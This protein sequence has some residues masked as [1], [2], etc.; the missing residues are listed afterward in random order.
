MN[1]RR[2]RLCLAIVVF[3]S[4][5]WHSLVHAQ[6]MTKFRLYSASDGISDD[7]ITAI[8]QD[9]HGYLW[10]STQ[11]GLNRYDGRH[12]VQFHAGDGNNSLPDEGVTRLVW[13]DKNRLAAYTGVGLHIINTPDG[14]TEDIIIPAPDP[15]Y[16]YKYNG[17]MSVL[18]D[19]LE[20]IYLL[21]QSGFYH[22]DKD[23]RL[24]FRYDN[25][26][27]EEISTAT[28]Q[29][30]EH[31]FWM[32]P[33]EI[34]LNTINGCY[35]YNTKDRKLVVLPR[36]NPLLHELADVPP[37]YYMIRQPSP[38]SLIYIKAASDS[39]VY[40]DV[41]RGRKI[42]SPTGF[43]P[44]TDEFNWYSRLFKV[45]DS[46]YYL[47]SRRRGFFKM[48]LDAASGKIAIDTTRYF[49]EYLCNGFVIDRDNRLWVA[50]TSGL[51]K[52]T[53]NASSVRQAAIPSDLLKKAPGLNIRQMLCY[54]DKLY[55]ACSG[56]GGLLVYDKQS[57]SFLYKVR[58]K[59]DATGTENVFSII[60]ARADTLLIGTNGPLCWLKTSTGETGE[61][62]LAGWDSVHNWISY[63]FKDRRENIWV[64]TNDNSKIYLQ[65]AGA[66]SFKRL[67]FDHGNFK[68]ILLNSAITEDKGGNI[69]I[70][71]HGISRVNRTT[72]QPDFFLDSFPT[73]RFPR[74]QVTTIRFDKYNI[75]WAG[76]VNNGLAGYDVYK[77]TYRHFT[78]KDDLPDNFIKSLYPIGNKLWIATA[79]GIATL[80]LLTNKVSKFSTSDGFSSMPVSSTNFYY[81]SAARHLYSGFTNHIIRFNPDSLFYTEAPPSLSI[82]S[83]RVND[84]VFYHPGEIMTLP[85]SK[86][87]M[88]VTVGSINYNDV[89]NQRIAYRMADAKDVSWQPLTGDLI[90]FNDLPPGNYRLQVRASAANNRWPIQIKELRIVIRPPFWRTSWFLVL[91]GVL[92]LLLIYLIYRF[93]VNMVRKQER[94]KVL[95]QELKT[96]EYRN[97]LELE[98]IINYFSTSLAGKKNISEVLWDVAG[99]LIGHMGYKDCMIYLWDA[100]R[101]KMIQKAGHG[102]KATPEAIH[103]NVF[104]VIA[105][106]GVVGYVMKTKKPVLIAD[107]RKDK[108]YRPDDVFR[109]SEICVPIMH[110]GDLLGIIDAEHASPNYYKE[111]DLKILTTIATLIGN[112]IKQ[113]ESE[114][115]LAM[116]RYELAI[117]NEQLAEAQLTALQTQMNPHFIFNAL[118]SIKRMIL[119]NESANA[120][121]YLSKFAQ[122]IRLTLNHSRETFVRLQETIE[123]LHAYLE[124]EQLRFGSSFSYTIDTN[125]SPDEEDI[126]IPTLMIQ[127]LAENAIWHGLMH[128]AG[129]KKVMIRFVHVNDMVT[130]TIEDNGIGIRASEKMKRINKP[131]QV[132]LGNLRNRIKIMN[133]K[134]D[135]NCTLEI[136]DLG[137]TDPN[138]TGTL[139]ILQFKITRKKYY[140]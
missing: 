114:Q 50:T 58:F 37:F 115:S 122:M 117:I 140:Q 126:R 38:G 36:N 98:K 30:G 67:D 42:A 26:A 28:F 81:D 18:S 49:G 17:I 33:F 12:F 3:L 77:G 72:G 83:I 134:Y 13:L 90:N 91:M 40:V 139:A 22:Y 113:M 35:L 136:N 99:N 84:T 80:D 82:E 132:G 119:D 52:E 129:D 44:L 88:T 24:V 97:R 47:T 64:T 103:K 66:G 79:T 11:R 130:C 100:D 131:P 96:E 62:P 8:E 56:R 19:P 74:R 110:N 69:W 41:K 73:I 112:K 65:P 93:K 92:G 4:M 107:T 14:K 34:L 48:H 60:H 7:N 111:R 15:R 20:N 5:G 21:T 63:V 101:T 25:Y 116:K 10:V 85:Y 16:L 1:A 32:S 51:L 70:S 128:R 23:H 59:N 106:Q 75:L 95:L 46:L 121:R 109:L 57:L 87:S 105:G 104:D 43:R 53:K 127:P 2:N 124:M 39:V 137:E 94:A 123:Y 78:T 31:I 133:E 68:K 118:N 55:V 45:N 29:F 9:A 135:M 6:D 27:T 61:V 86:N 89:S 108:R 102:L 54:K 76:V 120:S 71:G 138:R 125:R